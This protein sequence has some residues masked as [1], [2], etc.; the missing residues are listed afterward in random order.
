MAKAVPTAKPKSVVKR[1]PALI[2]TGA[3]TLIA[4]AL[5]V[6]PSLGIPVPGTV[7][8]IVAAG[9]TILAGFGIRPQVTPISR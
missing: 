9:L 1:E 8:K 4:T 6:A 7:Q 5:F 2:L 3:A